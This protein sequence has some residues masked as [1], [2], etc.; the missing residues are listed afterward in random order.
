MKRLQNRTIKRFL[1]SVALLGAGL[2][3][4]TA[5]GPSQPPPTAESPTSSAAQNTETSTPSVTAFDLLPLKQGNQ[6][7][8]EVESTQTDANGRT[9]S[10]GLRTWV[11]KKVTE[12]NGWKDAVIEERTD[13][14]ELV[15]TYEVRVTQDAISFKSIVQ[16]GKKFTI[17]P[18]LPICQWPMKQG[19]PIEW[20]GTGISQDPNLKLKT[21]ITYTGEMEVDAA[22]ERVKALRFEIV[23]EPA[24][25][26][27]V[28]ASQSTYWFK[29][30]VGVV[31]TV[32][33]QLQRSFVRKTV[34]RLK[35]ATVQ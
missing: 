2:A 15:N 4:L 32:D 20:K 34:L 14:D 25:G 26:S 3:L 22:D 27:R 28:P 19:E 12:G 11:V 10:V 35:G 24:D 21:T 7:T 18:P 29:P 33:T 17:Q 30:G 31:R 16:G 1:G 9:L 23:S 6:W 8:Y 13:K 5:C